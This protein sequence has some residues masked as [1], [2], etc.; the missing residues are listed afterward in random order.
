MGIADLCRDVERERG[1][2]VYMCL[3]VYSFVLEEFSESHDHN[4][5]RTCIHRLEI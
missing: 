4:Y 1:V 3:H 2:C 5:I